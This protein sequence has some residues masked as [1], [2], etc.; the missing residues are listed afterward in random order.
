MAL[1]KPTA[2]ALQ[3]APRG[4]GADIQAR[5]EELVLLRDPFGQASEQF[6]RL[7]NT[8]VALNPDGAARSILMTS[9]IRGEGKTVATLNLGIAL[10]ELPQMRVLVLDGDV[11]NPALEEYMGLPRRQG[12][13]EILRGT[14]SLDDGIRATSIERLDIV[15]VGEIPDNPAEVLNEDRIRATLN[16]CK[17]RYDYVLIDGPA[18]LSIVHPSMIGS[19][20][21]GIIM[22]VR[23]S[24]TP[25]HLIEEAHQLLES[26]GG[27]VLGTCVTGAE[28]RDQR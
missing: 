17:R 4:E 15:G 9:A 1:F 5:R 21:D 13:C 14:L 7:R 24:V 3:P 22:V 6:R 26:L 25:K 28:V 23:L 27:N 8:I 11:Q 19:M 10:A 2:Q 16:A 12:F 20:A 18:A